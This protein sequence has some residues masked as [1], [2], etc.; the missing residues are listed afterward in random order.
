MV[1]ALPLLMSVMLAQEPSSS[2][3][4]ENTDF[5]FVCKVGGKQASIT[6]EAGLLTYRFGTPRRPQL[7]IRQSLSRPNVFYRNDS[8]PHSWSDQLRFTRGLYSYGMTNWVVAGS[9]GDEGIGLFV[10]REGKVVSWRPCGGRDW[11]D[12][13]NHF[14]NLPEDPLENVWVAQDR[15]K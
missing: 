6:R 5:H 14:E 11:F 10:M 4:N 8:W 7:T 15:P 13:S 12:G 1:F 3:M 9:D 2:R